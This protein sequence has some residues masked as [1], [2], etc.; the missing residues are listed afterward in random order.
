MCK[1]FR[2]TI[3]VFKAIPKATAV[4][5]AVRAGVEQSIGWEAECH[6]VYTTGYVMTCCGTTQEEVISNVHNQI[7]TLIRERDVY[8]ANNPTAG[9]CDI[10]SSSSST[11]MYNLNNDK[12]SFSSSATTITAN[13]SDY[14]GGFYE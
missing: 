13:F 9:S 12:F 8:M 11:T 7:K 6:D 4:I 14:S 2:F 5:M 3:V 1:G 10:N